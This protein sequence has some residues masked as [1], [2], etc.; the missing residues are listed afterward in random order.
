MDDRLLAVAAAF[1]LAVVMGA[2]KVRR[3]VEHPDEY[4][5]RHYTDEPLVEPPHDLKRADGEQ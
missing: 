5:Q 3:M 4:V 2:L 1:V